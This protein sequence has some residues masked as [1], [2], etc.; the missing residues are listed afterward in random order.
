MHQLSI[1]IY[2]LSFPATVFFL[3][4]LFVVWVLLHRWSKSLST[5]KKLMFKL[6]L[7][8]LFLLWFLIVLSQTV[9]SRTSGELVINRDFFHHLKN[10]LFHHG[11]EEELRTLW[12]NVLLFVPGG[13]LLEVLWPRCFPRWV[14]IPLTIILLTG[15]SVGIETV[16]YRYALGCVEADDVLCNS[17]GAALGVVIHECAVLLSHKDFTSKL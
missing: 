5:G 3:I 12:M 16:Q 9:L 10:Y 17:L 13:L 4:I 11:H 2:A 1:T 6:F 15:L 7:T 8:T 14:C